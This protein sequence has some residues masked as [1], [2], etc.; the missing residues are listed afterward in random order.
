LRECGALAVILPELDRLFGVP[1]P[2]QYHPEI[3]TGEHTMQVIDQ[4][5]RAGHPLEIRWACLL[6]DLGKGET[7]ADI[8][9]HHYAHESR[10]E[11]LARRISDRLRA[12]AACRNFA[13]LFAR[14]HGHLGRIDEMRP[15]TVVEVLERC[16]CARR[17]ERFLAMLDAAACDY[18]GRGGHWPA[19]W[20]PGARWQ[21]AMKAFLAVDAGAL[22][23]SVPDRHLIP[24]RLHAARTVAVRAC[25]DHDSPIHRKPLQ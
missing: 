4:A 21:Q 7:P 23:Q 1:Q 22:A 18:F 9:P 17:P 5:A 25:L 2:P 11:P 19:P 3:D 6:H 12:P 14:E 20:P 10:G 16:D 15:G 8:L 13:A 24:E